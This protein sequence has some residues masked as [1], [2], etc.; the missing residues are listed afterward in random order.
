[1]NIVEIKKELRKQMLQKRADFLSTSKFAYD[2]WICRRLQ[3][4]VLNENFKIVHLYLPMGN[5]I[6]ITPFIEFCLKNKIT[7]VCPKTLKKRNLKHLVLN[8]LKEVET[9]VFGTMYPSN[10][11][12]YLGEYDLIVVPGLA[13]DENN[14]RL[15]Y[16]GGYYDSFLCKHPEANKVGIFYSF[17]E[18]EKIPT[19]QHD[20]ALDLILSK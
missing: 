4:L 20:L 16:G 7:V 15:G 13:F 5:E 9:G 6:D 17:Q 11:K 18:V 12:E 3:E 10:T 2:L 19:E 1:M 14:N 8:S